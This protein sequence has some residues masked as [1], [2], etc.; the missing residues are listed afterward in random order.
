MMLFL[1]ELLFKKCYYFYVT[2]RWIEWCAVCN[3]MVSRVNISLTSVYEAT[4][5]A[6]TKTAPIV[7]VVY[8]NSPN[9]TGCLYATFS[10]LAALSCFGFSRFSIILNFMM[11]P[12]TFKRCVAQLSESG[13]I[14]DFSSG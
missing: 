12:P 14:L 5:L 6:Q 4:M 10:F 3:P 2:M 13:R 9:Q 11:R 8:S 7:S 1:Y